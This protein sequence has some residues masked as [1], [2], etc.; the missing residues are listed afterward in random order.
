MKNTDYC[1]YLLFTI[2]TLAVVV[3]LPTIKESFADTVIDTIEIG[4]APRDIAYNTDNKYMYVTSA[5]GVVVID[6]STNSII[7]T[8]PI[9]NAES[10]VY[11]S[12]NNDMYVT[13]SSG[14]I[15][16]IDSST[17][18]VVENINVLSHGSIAYNAEN[19]YV[20]V[21]YNG[22]DGFNDLVSFIDT[23][24]NAVAGNFTLEGIL[25]QIEYNPANN[26]MY[27]TRYLT[28]ERGA[29][30]IDTSTHSVVASVAMGSSSLAFNPFNSYMYGGGYYGI[31]W[32]D[33]STNA[34][35]DTLPLSC[36]GDQVP[37]ITSLAYNPDNNYMYAGYSPDSVYMIDSST[38]TLVDT[39]NVGQAPRSMAHN[40]FNGYMYVTNSASHSISVLAPDNILEPPINTGIISAVDDMSMP[41]QNESST[42]ST[43]I[44]F[45]VQ[46]D[47]GTNPIVGF[48]CSL[49]GSEFSN[50]SNSNPTTITYNDLA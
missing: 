6:S 15:T 36:E 10:I 11:N 39:I 45:K 17:N 35:V 24:T 44:T 38:N 14:G 32:V 8:I 30:V 2:V 48:E 33:S 21:I 47:A 4:S 43:S 40:P 23:D 41:I 22:Y 12:M 50:C 26:D 42:T 46:A 5:E 27:I 19:N 49:D 7:D 20:Y 18:T 13:S 37:C 34:V 28:G 31:T 3:S 29:Y 25:S 16:V 1:I 9:P